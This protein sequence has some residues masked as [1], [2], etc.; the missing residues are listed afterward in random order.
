[1][2]ADQDRPETAWRAFYVKPRHEKKVANRLEEDG[3]EVFCPLVTRKVQWS[4]R[5]KKVEKPLINGYVFANVTEKERRAAVEDPG[6]FRTVFWKGKPALIRDE[7]IEIMR[8]LL[9]HSEKVAVGKY[10]PGDRVRVSEGGYSLGIVGMEGIV[11]E[12]HGR[13]VSLQLE[14]LQIQLSITV[15][16]YM[17][18]KLNQNGRQDE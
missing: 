4:D 11:A 5:I 6:I 13:T 12:V 3:I 15:P 14:S 8:Q 1:M 2:N 17:L 9:N 7:E 18:E 10:Q 16:Q